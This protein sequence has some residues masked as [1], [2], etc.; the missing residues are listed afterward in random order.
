M[1]VIVFIEIMSTYPFMNF[2]D[3]I[4]VTQHNEGITLKTIDK[5]T[6]SLINKESQDNQSNKSK[7]TNDMMETCHTLQRRR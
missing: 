5:D 4:M 6:S 3:I 2:F 7:D 1:N